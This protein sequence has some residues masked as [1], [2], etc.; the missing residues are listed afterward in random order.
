MVKDDDRSACDDKNLKYA[1]LVIINTITWLINYQ[2]CMPLVL[3]QL[4]RS[5]LAKEKALNCSFTLTTNACWTG[6]S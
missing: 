6:L 5:I 3:V 4:L 2:Y 1:V